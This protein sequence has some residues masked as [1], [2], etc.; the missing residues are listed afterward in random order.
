MSLR[1]IHKVIA[2]ALIVLGHETRAERLAELSRLCN[3]P[4]AAFAALRDDEYPTVMA[5][6]DRRVLALWDEAKWNEI[7]AGLRRDGWHV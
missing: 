7:L 1:E 2:D 3:R 6:L 4:V 5:D